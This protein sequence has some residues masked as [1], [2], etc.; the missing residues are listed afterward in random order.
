MYIGVA[1]DVNGVG[2]GDVV[3]RVVA[4]IKFFFRIDGMATRAVRIGLMRASSGVLVLAS[5][6]LIRVLG[7]RS[8][9]ALRGGLMGMMSL[10]PGLSKSRC[11]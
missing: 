4:R 9:T 7:L 3:N 5:W 8:G 2:V 11:G 1:D 10:M 6:V